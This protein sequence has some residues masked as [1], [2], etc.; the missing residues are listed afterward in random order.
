MDAGQF[1]E[2]TKGLASEVQQKKMAR[3]GGAY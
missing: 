3:K 1:A 2:S